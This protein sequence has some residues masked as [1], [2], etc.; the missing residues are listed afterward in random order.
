MRREDFV[1]KVKNMQRV[2]DVPLEVYVSTHLDRYRKPSIEFWKLFAERVGEIDFMNSFYCGDSAGRKVNPTTKQADL[3]DSDYKFALNIGI[4][5]IT[6]EELFLPEKQISKK[7]QHQLPNYQAY[8]DA[9]VQAKNAVK[10]EDLLK[11]IIEY[12]ESHRAVKTVI[13]VFGPPCSGK[14]TLL[15]HLPYPSLAGTQ[16][17][18]TTLRSFLSNLQTRLDTLKEPSPVVLELSTSLLASLGTSTARQH[19]IKQLHAS[20]LRVLAL[21]LSL[22]RLLCEHWHR[23][24]RVT[25][26]AT[27]SHK[28][29]ALSGWDSY[30][31]GRKEEGWEHRWMV[32]GPWRGAGEDDMIR[33]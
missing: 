15:A 32:E 20:G 14:T 10:V 16:K 18:S 5:F 7:L 22:P 27:T 11:D 12:I 6:P 1:N 23:V 24:R 4:P 30:Q 9:L 29:E 21:E 31:G 8:Q 26:A 19:L 2:L 3:K 25:T 33:Y 13:L 28:G 17:P